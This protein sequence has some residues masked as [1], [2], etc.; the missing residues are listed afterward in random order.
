[1][2]MYIYVKSAKGRT[3]SVYL[4]V[5]ISAVWFF[6]F[7]QLFFQGHVVY[8]G[9]ITHY[10]DNAWFSDADC[11]WS[12]AVSIA[13]NAV[14][15]AAVQFFYARRL[16]L[17][18]EGI[19]VLPIAIAL[20]AFVGLAFGLV[21]VAFTFKIVVF[22]QFGDLI[23]VVDAWL[24]LLIAADVA[25]VSAMCWYLGH[26][27]TGFNHTDVLIDR[28]LFLT[29]NTG[30]LPTVMEVAHVISFTVARDNFAH[31]TFNF[32]APKLYAN[33]LLAT[34]NA[35]DSLSSKQKGHMNGTVSVVASPQLG[36]FARGG[37]TDRYE[38][39]SFVQD[40]DL[41]YKLSS[42]PNTP[43]TPPMSATVKVIE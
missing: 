2:Q 27:R 34:L 4:K 42:S 29:V 26:K 6:D 22:E 41:Y 15:A 1:V 11:Q 5:F 17:L 20:L 7:I 9:L 43:R 19:R 16:L 13:F 40:A 14:I 28:L 37:P 32:V 31:M 38:L 8:S 23:W 30:L 12:L 35:R 10:G 24:G 18:S 36:T 21:T 33:S 3:D 39:R 25:I